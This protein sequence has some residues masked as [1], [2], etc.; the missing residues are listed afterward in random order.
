MLGHARESQ[1]RPPTEPALILLD[2][3]RIGREGVSDSGGGVTD[4]Q[5][6]WGGSNVRP[7]RTTERQGVT[8]RT[9]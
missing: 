3:V 2:D 6:D 5:E 8:W 4:N 1:P 9:R 7:V